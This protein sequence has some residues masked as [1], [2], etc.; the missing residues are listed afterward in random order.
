MGA[1]SAASFL[2][3]GHSDVP[4]ATFG[5]M[6]ASQRSP[7]MSASRGIR[8]GAAIGTVGGALRAAGSFAPSLIASD[9]ARTWLY[10]GIDMCLALGLAS[11]FLARR[12][13]MRAAAILGCS[14]TLGGLIVGRLGP[15]MTNLD[16]Y[17][18]TAA[19]VAIGAEVIKEEVVEPVRVSEGTSS[20]KIFATDGHGLGGYRTS[21]RLD[22]QPIVRSRRR[23]RLTSRLSGGPGPTRRAIVR[24]ASVPS[25]LPLRST[26]CAGWRP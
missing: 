26:R 6:V 18:V 2:R 16:L 8:T 4:W 12:Q 25:R 1:G 15:F 14:L 24:L 22:G 10:V 3:K 7:T 9:T 13:G 21:I 20:S 5:Y 11:L 17:P 19:A 23:V